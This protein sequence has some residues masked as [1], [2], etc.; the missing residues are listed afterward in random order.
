LDP[1]SSKEYPHP[2]ISNE[3]RVQ[4]LWDDLARR[5]LHPFPLP[6]GVLLDESA[7]NTSPCIRCD[8]CDGYPCLAKAKSDSQTICIEPALDQYPNVMLRTDARVVRL[9][10]DPSG[11]RVSRVVVDRLGEREEYSADIVVLS[12]G[13]IN[14]AALLL[15]SANERHPHGLGNSSSVVGR[16]LMLHH[17]SALIAFSTSPNPTLFQKTM[18]IND[19]YYGDPD[20]APGEW[21]YPLG[22]MQ[23]L[24]KQDASAFEGPG[25]A[26]LARHAVEFW[27][28][29]EDLPDADNRVTVEPDGTLRVSYTD[30]NA[31]AHQRLIDKWKGLLET[32]RCGDEY[33]EAGHYAGGRNTIEGVSHQNGTVRFGLDPHTSA[34]DVNCKMHDLDNLYVVDSSFFCSSSAVNP[35]LTIIANALRVADHIASRL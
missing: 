27:L 11:G 8:T 1:W 20:A 16:N 28:T 14:S 25:A 5:G 21:E 30:T 19:F 2:P 24:G 15:N 29:T 10:T 23:M 17:N 35:T 31:V 26:D 13:A 6:M 7:P 34:L 12:A 4:Q 3:P 22:A 18:G 33:F 9:D 32:M